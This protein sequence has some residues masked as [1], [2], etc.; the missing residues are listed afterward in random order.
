MYNRIAFL[1]DFL[2][3]D[4][5][6]YNDEE[7]V[8]FSNMDLDGLDTFYIDFNKL[9]NSLQEKSKEAT[10]V[11]DLSDTDIMVIHRDLGSTAYWAVE[12]RNLEEDPITAL[13]EAL[14]YEDKCYANL[15]NLDD[16]EV[17]QEYKDLL[18]KYIN[19]YVNK[20]WSD[21]VKVPL[22]S[23]KGYLLIEGDFEN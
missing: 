17:S 6:S 9:P 15:K 5:E 7:K 18:N 10:G 4:F 1:N 22:D 2:R 11:S 12:S 19:D 21:Y 14:N 23:G 16:P 8:I 13:E 3:Y 20:E